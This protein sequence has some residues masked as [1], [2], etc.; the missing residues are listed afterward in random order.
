MARGEFNNG[1]ECNIPEG[2][3]CEPHQVYKYKNWVKLCKT[4]RSYFVAWKENRGP[5]QKKG[6]KTRQ[7]KKKTR[8]A[9][10]GAGSELIKIFKWMSLGMIAPC[11]GCRGLA[12]EM[13]SRGPNWCENSM[14]Y[15]LR[16]IKE[17]SEEL[18][19]PFNKGL[20]RKCVQWAIKRAR[21]YEARENKK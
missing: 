13:N 8:D 21:R 15:I 7:G 12:T 5:G 16:R 10:R 6:K 14:G 11:E 4:N 19:V 20:I 17:N 18:G 1:C 9:T 3:Y 2:G